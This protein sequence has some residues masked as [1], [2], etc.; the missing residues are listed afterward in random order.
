MVFELKKEDRGRFAETRRNCRSGKAVRNYSSYSKMF[1]HPSFP[2]DIRHTPKFSRTV[3]VWAQAQL[4]DD[5][6]R[7][8]SRFA[9]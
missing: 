9:V 1:E 8:H 7:E 5:P 2:F 3:A 6:S 4:I